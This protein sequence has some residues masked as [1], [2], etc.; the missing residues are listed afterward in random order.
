MKIHKKYP[1]LFKL[2]IAGTLGILGWFAP[3][4]PL[5]I[6]LGIF[7]TIFF[8][9][10]LPK[11]K[12]GFIILSFII[13][14][15]S[16]SITSFLNSK[17]IFTFPFFNFYSYN[18]SNNSRTIEPSASIETSKSVEIRLNG[19]V[20]VYLEEGNSIRYPAQLNAQISETNTKFTGGERNKT[21]IFYIGTDYLKFL[22][23][24]STGIVIYGKNTTMLERLDVNGTG[25]KINGDINSRDFDID[26]TGIVLNGNF[27]GTYM[28]V[29]GTGISIN[30]KYNVE[31]ID[32]DGTGIK[33]NVTIKN[34]YDIEISGTAVSGV[35]EYA[36][37]NDSFKRSLSVHGTS[38]SITIKNSKGIDIKVRG[39]KVIL[40]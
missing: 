2:L 6:I 12:I 24:N 28:N 33:L 22:N 31:T 15:P 3:F 1:V 16:L 26:G 32:I 38:G 18:N 30:G 8:A 20:I 25:I 27:S 17:F 11:G 10:I 23:V 34:S 7:G 21:Y 4:W 40:R 13:F 9:L 39:P 37:S 29:D 14:I 36:P 5:K 35:L 19:G